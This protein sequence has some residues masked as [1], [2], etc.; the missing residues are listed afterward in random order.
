M[1]P[2]LLWQIEVVPGGSMMG[3]MDVEYFSRRMLEER[4]AAARAT[5]AASAIHN[6]LAEK[7]AGVIEAYLKA[8]AAQR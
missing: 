1:L 3:N 6:E 7:Y 5:P 2:R 4:E 8:G